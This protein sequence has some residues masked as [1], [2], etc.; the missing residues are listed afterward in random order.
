MWNIVSTEQDVGGNNY[1]KKPN[2]EKRLFSYVSFFIYTAVKLQSE[3]RVALLE[4]INF[5]F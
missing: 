2:K 4:I 5:A 3:A 1:K